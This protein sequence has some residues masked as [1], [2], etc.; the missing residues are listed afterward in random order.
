MLDKAKKNFQSSDT[1]YFI[2]A[3]FS[4]SDWKNHLNESDGF[5][6]VVSGFSIHH[7]PN[8]RK[9]EIYKEIYD[10]LNPKGIFLNLEHVSSAT[11]EIEAVFDDYFIDHLYSYQRKTNSGVKRDVIAEKHY[12]RSDKVE[13]ILTSLE[14]QCEWLRQIGYEDVDCFF[15]I[16]EL[17]L[18]GGRKP[19][20]LI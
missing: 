4:L 17:T 6:L 20:L 5:D 12:N 1:V 15:K 2:N 8:A 14:L 7:Q 18:F 13:N 3:D 11:K 9:K 19:I 16:F 10:L